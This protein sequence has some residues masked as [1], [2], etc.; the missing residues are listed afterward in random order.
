MILSMYVCLRVLLG[1]KPCYGSYQSWKTWKVMEFEI[2]IFPGL[3]SHGIEIVIFP[4]LEG[5]GIG[6]WLFWVWFDIIMTYNVKLHVFFPVNWSGKFNWF[7][8]ESRSFICVVI[9]S[10]CMHACVQVKLFR[11]LAF[12]SFFLIKIPI[13][14]I[15]A[16]Q[17]YWSWTKSLSWNVFYLKPHLRLIKFLEYSIN[18][19][20]SIYACA[21][22]NQHVLFAHFALTITTYVQ[23]N[24]NSI[25]YSEYI[26]L[27]GEIVVFAFNSVLRHWRYL[28]ITWFTLI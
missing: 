5:H 16:F 11:I 18:D 22:W 12:R 25:S 28:E 4:G 6:R 3:E 27:G 13:F 9:I 21:Y 2:V 20:Q 19:F 23:Y 26:F 10:V 24:N 17:K 14:K 7:C 1:R 15:S 8:T